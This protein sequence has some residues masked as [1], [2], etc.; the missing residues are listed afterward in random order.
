MTDPAPDASAESPASPG[1]RWSARLRSRTRFLAALA[2]L[3]AIGSLGALMFGYVWPVTLEPASGSRLITDLLAFMLVTF[4]FHIGL[5]VL[6]VAVGALATRR[7]RLLALGASVAALGLAPELWLLR[8]RERSAASH[9]PEL[10][11][12]SVNMLYSRAD[13][14][15]LRAEIDRIEPDVILFQEYTVTAEQVLPGL[16]ADFPHIAQAARDDAFGQAVYSKLPFEERVSNYP[17]IGSWIIPQ[18][19]AVLA[20]GD[21]RIG[22]LNVHVVPP[23]S[24]EYYTDQRAQ[25]AA[26]ARYVTDLLRSGKEDGLIVMGDFNATPQSSHLAAVR[27]AGLV[28]AHQVAG[29]GRGSTWPRTGMLRYA[30]GI[31]LDHALVGVAL[32]P[33]H[34]VVGDDIGSDHRPIAVRVSWKPNAN[35]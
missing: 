12:M 19:Y 16:L 34:A 7:W 35:R 18:Q 1:I 13:P 29:R 26:I 22:L 9:S 11:V 8:P 6:I 4:R 15:K 5:G 24:L 10:V 17:S 33:L 31:R 3:V 32:E 20:F 25:T 14:A 28:D 30:P 27:S 21:R 23:V 2:W